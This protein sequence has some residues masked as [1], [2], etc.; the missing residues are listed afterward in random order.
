MQGQRRDCMP[1]SPE[2]NVFPI[3]HTVVRL[4]RTVDKVPYNIALVLEDFI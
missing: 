4:F 2:K 3:C 1:C